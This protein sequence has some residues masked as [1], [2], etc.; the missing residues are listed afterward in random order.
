MHVSGNGRHSDYAVQWANVR[1]RIRTLLGMWHK[2]E[3][4]YDFTERHDLF[5]N[6][7]KLYV[8]WGPSAIHIFM[9]KILQLYTQT[10]N[11]FRAMKEFYGVW[12][13]MFLTIF[14][15]HR[16]NREPM[17]RFYWNCSVDGI[18]PK[19]NNFLAIILQDSETK[20]RDCHAMFCSTSWK[21]FY[22]VSTQHLRSI[23]W[24]CNVKIQ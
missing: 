6:E 2:S 10:I 1:Q 11:F 18:M 7:I 15:A 24:I 16:T 21:L 14:R 4:F 3:T 17:L 20:I 22:F 23:R 12:R 8:L 19:N 5:K 9:E 13:R